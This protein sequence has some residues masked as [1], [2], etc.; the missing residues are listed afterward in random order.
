LCPIVTIADVVEQIRRAF[1]L[2]WQRLGR[3]IFAYGWSAGGHLTAAM[4]ATAWASLYP[5]APGDLVPAGYAISG[6]Y[7]LTPLIGTSMNEDLKLDAETARQVSPLFWPIPAGRSL[8]AVVGSLESSEF[9]RQSQIIVQGWQG[10]A[11]TRGE[12]IAGAHHFNVIAPLADPNS[13][14]VARVAELAQRLK[15]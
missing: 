4:V 1:V 5:K 7:D 13:A 12:E 10:A 3:R 6:L 9:R 11:Q 14:M 8:D 15:A 2:L